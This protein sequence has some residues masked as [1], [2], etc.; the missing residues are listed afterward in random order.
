M[1]RYLLD[2]SALLTLKHEELGADEVEYIL[3]QA[4]YGKVEVWVSFITF[5]ELFYIVWQKQGQEEAYRIFLE[6]KALPIKKIDTNES[7]GLIAGELKAKF[8]ISVAD[9]WIA[10]SSVQ[11][12][13]I[14][15][16]KDPEF[17]SLKDILELQA[18]PYKKIKTS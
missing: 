18:L 14:L 1:K 16:H 7:L 17:E 4:S 9:S 2:T 11:I 13:A 5:M 10:A 8:S 15:V 6:T 3:R 12:Q